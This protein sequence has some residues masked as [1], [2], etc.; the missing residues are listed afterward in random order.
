MKQILLLILVGVTIG[1]L[2]GCSDETVPDQKTADAMNKFRAQRSPEAVKG[3]AG[4][5]NPATAP[6]AAGAPGAPGAPAAGGA[7]PPPDGK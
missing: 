7:T 1:A 4:G 6:G 2:A 3:G 5:A